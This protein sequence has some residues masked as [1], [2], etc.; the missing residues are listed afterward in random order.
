[1]KKSD[2][3]KNIGKE[4]IITESVIAGLSRKKGTIKAVHGDEYMGFRYEVK[5]TSTLEKAHPIFGLALISYYPSC[6]LCEVIEP[7]IK[8]FHCPN[9]M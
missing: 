9:T 2:L 7:K 3:E 8:N 5:L 1:M 6:S 4:C